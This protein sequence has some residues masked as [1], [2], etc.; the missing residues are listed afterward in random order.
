MSEFFGGRV[1][2]GGGSNAPSGR[3]GGGAASFFNELK[4]NVQPLFDGKGPLAREREESAGA[5]RGWPDSSASRANY[6]PNQL[7]YQ[8]RVR[9]VP[10]AARS[11]PATMNQAQQQTTWGRGN[12]PQ[13]PLPPRSQIQR[14]PQPQPQPQSNQPAWQ[15]QRYG[16]DSTKSMSGMARGTGGMEA[17][18]RDTGKGRAQPP[19]EADPVSSPSSKASGKTAVK[20]VGIGAATAAAASTVGA[21]SESSAAP[22][23]PAGV[24]S[25]LAQGGHNNEDERN[26]NDDDDD[27]DD[28]LEYQKSPFDDD[29]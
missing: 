9:K 27:D 26:D 6:D 23:P 17:P 14:H 25:V 5:G 4:A 11:P 13:P 1:G 15:Q 7:A 29:D 22:E 12:S 19:P 8:P 16:D 2:A 10:G 20:G 18:P 3:G 24:A 21:S 28:D